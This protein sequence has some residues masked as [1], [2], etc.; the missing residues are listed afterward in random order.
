MYF[1]ACTLAISLNILETVPIFITIRWSGGIV[2]RDTYLRI[3]L[4]GKSVF[5]QLPSISQNAFSFP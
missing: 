5:S 3:S 1:Q 4:I 2:V